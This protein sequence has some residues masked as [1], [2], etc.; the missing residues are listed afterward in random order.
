MSWTREHQEEKRAR[1]IELNNSVASN[2]ESWKSSVQ[3]A[4]GNTEAVDVTSKKQVV[5]GSV[6]QFREF[7]NE[8]RT[9]SE[10]VTANGTTMDDIAR[11]AAEVA[12][13]KENLR[14]LKEKQGTRT[15]QAQS[16]NPKVTQSPFVNALWL[17]RNFR[18]DTRIGLIVASVV[19]GILALGS[20]GFLIYSVV[21]GG[22]IKP[23]L[24]TAQ[25]GGRRRVRFADDT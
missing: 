4:M 25:Q 13:E 20:M 22:V 5:D 8:L 16:V 21:A 10:Q 19:I 9:R 12:E 23:S 18:E 17:R 6:R 14:R 7:V 2:I 24:Y 3:T 11:L 1:L 15:E